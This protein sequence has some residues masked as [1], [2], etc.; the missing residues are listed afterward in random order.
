MTNRV[1]I[2][3]GASVVLTLL[4]IGVILIFGESCPVVIWGGLTLIG[5][6]FVAFAYC[7]GAAFSDVQ[8]PSRGRGRNQRPGASA[9]EE[10]PGAR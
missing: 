5:V 8:S 10:G 6:A 1:W 9:A 3:M 4:S 7:A 2:L